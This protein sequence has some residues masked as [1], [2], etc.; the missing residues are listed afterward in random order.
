MNKHLIELYPK[1]NFYGFLH[2]IKILHPII[3]LSILIEL[4]PCSGINSNEN[5]TT[6]ENYYV[7]A[8]NT[9]NSKLY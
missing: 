6:Q 3:F 7:F 4:I 9:E 1:L 2:R 5:Y 8:D